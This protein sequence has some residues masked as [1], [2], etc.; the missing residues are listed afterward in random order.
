MSEF[1]INGTVLGSNDIQ[2]DGLSV[3]GAAWHEIAVVPNPDSLQ[4]VSVTTNTFT[5][6]SGM[7]SGMVS[8][9]TKNGTNEFHGDLNFMLRNEDLNANGFYNNYYGLSRPS[10]RVLQGGGSIGGPVIIPKLYNGKNKLFFFASYLHLSHEDPE[11]VL[12][13]VPTCPDSTS[14]YMGERNG[15]FSQT[16]VRGVN[17][18]PE[19]VHLYNP[20][21]ATLVPGSTTEYQRQIY[22]NAIVT[23]P[24]PYGVELWNAYPCPN[25]TPN[26]AYNDN[27]YFFQGT[28]PETRD[29]LNAR[30]DYKLGQKQSIYFTAGFSKGSYTPQNIWGPN[31][32]FVNTNW[33]GVETDQNPYG[34][35]GDTITLNATTVIDV[36]YGVTHI[37]TLDN[38]PQGTAKA[39]DYGVPSSVGGLGSIPGGAPTVMPFWSVPDGGNGDNYGALSSSSWDS[40]KEHQLNHAVA[41]SITK[42]L[43]NWTMKGG[44]EYRVYLGNW[45]DVFWPTPNIGNQAQPTSTGEFSYITGDND[46]SAIADPA[47]RGYAGAI[48]IT[49]VSGFDISGGSL[50]LMSL[51]SKYVAFYTEDNWRPTRKLNL[52]LGLRYEVQPG[53]TERYNRMSSIN[54]NKANPFGAGAATTSNQ[55]GGMGILTFPG[56]DGYSRNLYQT[57]YTNVSPRVGATYQLNN[58]TV[59]R[60]GFGRNYLPSNTGFNANGLVYGPASFGASA[61]NIPYG[62]T[63]NGLPVGTFEQPQNTLVIPAVGAVQSPSLYGSPNFGVAFFDRYE[64]KTGLSDQWNVAVERTLGREW[65][66]SIGYIGSRTQHIEMSN[67]PLNGQWQVP[68]GTLQSWRNTWLTS[69]GANDPSQ[70]QVPNPL[71]YL[72]GRASGEIGKATISALQAQE[73]Y[74]PFLGQVENRS[75]GSTNYNSLVVRAQHAYTHGVLLMANYTWSKAMGITNVGTVGGLSNMEGQAGFTTGRGG[76]DYLNLHNNYSLL[77]FDTPNRFVAAVSYLLPIGKGLALDPGNRVARAIVGQWQV[78]SAVT[79]QSGNPFG[80]SCTTMNQ[81]CNVVEGEPV[82]VPKRLQHWY[83]GSTGVTLPDGRT[84]T[85]PQGSFLKYNPD[86]WTQPWVQFPNGTYA[87]D[88]YVNPTSPMAEGD[89]RTPSFQNVNISVVRKFDLRERGTLE[90][91]A[92]ATNAFNHVNILPTEANYGVYPVLTPGAGGAAVGM[93]ANTGFGTF[94]AGTLEPRQ[95]TLSAILKF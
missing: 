71:P 94:G 43:G 1:R 19:N 84:I 23:N 80:P 52:S 12:T 62:L 33:T 72:A 55:L 11:T 41:A 42:V 17:G 65:L 75:N 66:V 67:W 27:N 37:N 79:L 4:E 87:E 86:R 53:P 46:S 7:A 32:P 60:G 48:P 14:G 31:A 6:D 39:S 83:D 36:R 30:A 18:N 50:V 89:L 76:F 68:S 2:L 70:A 82:Q 24:D 38:V 45:Q 51:A 34:A 3:Q 13:T 85:P 28:I 61:E 44:G 40:K 20:F 88:Q 90:I 8:M 81:R 58:S 57:E 10:Y 47:D 95:L 92:D 74:L 54:L 78:S 93:N 59:I 64:Y 9:T 21:T 16:M 69:S 56:V 5:A 63:P 73:S 91:H 15:D 49:G 25:R 26:D 22:P 29:T 35:I 77:S